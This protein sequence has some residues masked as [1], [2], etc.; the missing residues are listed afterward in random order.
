MTKGSV[1][2][3]GGAGYIGSHTLRALARAGWRPVAFDDLSLGF[4]EAAK[5]FELIEG[6]VRDGPA[7]SRAIEAHGAVAVIHLAGLIEVARS[8]SRPDLFWDSNVAGTAALLSAMRA[9]A[10]PRLVFSSSAAVYGHVAGAAGEKPL[11]EDLP[12]AP[13]SPYGDTKL[14]GERMIAAHCAAF[15]LTAIAL[16]YFNAAGADPSGELGEAHEPET[17]LIPLAIDAALGQRGPLTVFGTDFPTPDGTCVRDYI[18]V[19]DLAEAHVAALEAPRAAGAFEPL[20]VGTGRGWSV[21]EVIAAVER[22]LGRPVPRALGPRRAGD[23]PS[24]VANPA[25]ALERLEW[26]P[27]SSSLDEIVASA[28]RWHRAP[29]YG[30]RGLGGDGP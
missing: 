12:K 10:V 9:H 19:S 23:P 5:G 18:H 30:K 27:K 11:T 22:A 13:A 1:L 17:H 8:V 15:G 16:R 7:L 29:R 20:N 2:V 3:T 21:L 24:L 4:A 26:R 6:D 28:A 25:R 14:A